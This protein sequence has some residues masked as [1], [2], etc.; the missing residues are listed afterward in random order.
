M[1]GVLYRGENIRVLVGTENGENHRI[2]RRG[3]DQ[4][5]IVRGEY[6]GEEHHPFPTGYC[7]STRPGLG[8][9]I[10]TTGVRLSNEAIDIIS[11]LIAA[12]R[13]KQNAGH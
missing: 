6:G 5:A 9:W 3:V 10:V 12:F 8:K 2:F 4:S 11:S 1:K 7:W 13:R